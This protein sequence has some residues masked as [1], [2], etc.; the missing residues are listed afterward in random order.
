M[1]SGAQEHCRSYYAA[2]VSH[3][4][5]YPALEGANATDVCIV[6]AGFTGISTALTLA[7]RGYKVA[8]VEANRVGWGASGR[9]GGQLIGGLSGEP[10]LVQHHGREIADLIW[11][12]GWRGHDIVHERV[13]RYD[14]PCDLKDGYLDVAIKPRHMTDLR[15]YYEELQR[16]DFP[17]EHRLLDAEELQSLIG[18]DAYIGGLL[19]MRNGHLHPLNLCIGLAQAAVGLGASIYE[20]SPVIDIRHG[21]RPQVVTA[22]GEIEADAVV[23]AGNAYH[24]LERRRLSGLTFPAGS[25]IIATEPLPPD[26]LQEIN[27]RDL[28]VCDP[29]NVLDYFR[30]SADGRMLFGGRCNYSGREPRSIQNA[31]QPRMAKIYPQLANVRIDYEWGGKIG[32]VINRV[33]LLG[34]IGGNVY[35]AQGY[36]GH[37]VN[38][39]HVAGEIVADAIGGTL[40]KLDIFERIRHVRI[41]LGQWFG[42]QLVALGMIYYRIRDLL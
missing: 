25:F 6:G 4:T 34:R 10:R 23:L 38:F 37:G 41:P 9:N 16:R 27:P 26:L 20:Q 13:A 40:E 17:Y 36:S 12:L 29:N 8:V 7:E 2:T 21:A 30:L 24:A 15:E 42:N 22:D 11:G 19:N 14:I 5:D 18:T 1:Q 33:P 35:F 3:R 28:S 39:T 31:I 32:I